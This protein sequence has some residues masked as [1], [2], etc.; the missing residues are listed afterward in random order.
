[1]ICENKP[2]YQMGLFLNWQAELDRFYYLLLKRLEENKYSPP[3]EAKVDTGSKV[4][5]LP[6]KE[7]LDIGVMPEGKKGSLWQTSE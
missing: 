5:W 2:F 4:S 1:M 6:K 7:L 3:V